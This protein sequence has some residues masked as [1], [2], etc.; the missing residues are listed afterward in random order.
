M[1]AAQAIAER[2]ARLYTVAAALARAATP[3]AVADAVLDQ[4][5]PALG[6]SGGGLL[7][8]AHDDR[9]ILPASR[10]YTPEVVAHLKAESMKLIAAAV[11]LRTGEAVW[12]ESR[13]DRDL[14]FPE[15][16]ELSRTPSRCA[17]CRWT[18][19]AGGWARCA[20]GF[21]EPRLFD[22]G[23]RRFVLT[24][25]AQTAQALERAQLPASTPAFGCSG[26]CSRRRSRRSPASRWR[27]CTTRW[28]TAWRWEATSTTSG[29]SMPDP[30][31][32]AIGDVVG[33]GP[34]PARD[35]HPRPVLRPGPVAA[36]ARRVVDRRRAQRPADLGVGVGRRRR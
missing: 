5:V 35:G 29:G 23:E 26:A 34:E 33:T 6:A 30:H 19:R 11:A 2:S 8:A 28:A 16:L 10:G 22:E 4:G 7:L 36:R 12:I 21:N 1:A 20:S 17:R 27:P 3:E 32:F 15:L 13:K 14:Q 9:L 24:M 25:A 31:G 18:C